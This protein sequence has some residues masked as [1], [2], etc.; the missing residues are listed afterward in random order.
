MLERLLAKRHI[1]SLDLDSVRLKVMKDLGWN[2][3]KT[4]EIELDYRRF[5]YALAHKPADLSISPPTQDVDEFWHRHI[6]DTRN[7]REDC[8]KVFGHYMD[9]TPGLTA[10]QQSGAD[11]RRREVYSK[12]NIDSMDFRRA[13]GESEGSF[14]MDGDGSSEPA[15]GNHTL[16]GGGHSDS[17]SDGHPGDSGH[18]GDA[19]HGGGD[20][21]SDVGSGGDGGGGDGGGGCGGGSCGGGCGGG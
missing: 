14:D 18:G 21:G 5:L 1:G 7:Y 16:H 11:A 20:S 12:H 2:V 17:H 9:H 4:D 6:L 15:H 3:E 19:G 10:E 8:D 13:D